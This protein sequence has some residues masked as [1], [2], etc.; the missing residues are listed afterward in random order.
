MA[1]EKE[2]HFFDRNYSR[3][4]DWY[5]KRFPRVDAHAVGEATQTYMYDGD[6]RNRMAATLPDARL[7][8]ILRDPVDRAYSHYWMNR[9]LGREDLGFVEA[10]NRERERILEAD[11][12]TRDYYS[13]LDRGR[14]VHQLQEICKLYPRERLLVL[15]FE[16]MIESPRTAYSKACEFLELSAEPIPELVGKRLNHFSR[17]RSLR[18]R[19][20]SKSLP[21]SVGR[22]IRRANTV[23]DSYPPMEPEIRS[24]IEDSYAEDNEALAKWLGLR[25]PWGG[26]AGEDPSSRQDP[27]GSSI[28]RDEGY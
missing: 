15:F 20:L 7:I 21:R 26:H 16:E 24:Q 27:A 22:F 3:G 5:R 14:Y 2:I 11:E 18:V 12:M 1:R 19:S 10:T 4:I 9:S 17:F 6:T 8:A 13:Y 25:P 23:A 28:D